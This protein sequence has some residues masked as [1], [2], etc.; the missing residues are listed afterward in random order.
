MAD[1]ADGLKPANE[2]PWYVLM[3]LYGEQ[4]G[5]EIDWDLHEKNKRAWNAWTFKRT[6]SATTDQL[7]ETKLNFLRD[8][9]IDRDS[10]RVSLLFRNRWNIKNKKTEPSV[11]VFSDQLDLSGTEFLNPLILDGFAFGNL[12]DLSGSKF[13]KGLSAQAAGFPKV[14]ELEEARSYKNINLVGSVFLSNLNAT[15]LQIDGIFDLSLAKVF[16]DFLFSDEYVS[17]QFRGKG[18][19]VE[20]KFDAFNREFKDDLIMRG[21]AIKGDVDFS[22]AEFHK[23]AHFIKATF[24][25]NIN[26]VWTTFVDE[27]N[28][29]GSTFKKRAIFRK[30]I[31]KGTVGF[32][33]SDFQGN[34]DFAE[35]VFAATGDNHMAAIRFTD[36]QFAKPTSFRNAR[37]LKSY[38]EFTNTDLHPVTDFSADTKTEKFWPKGVTEP[39]KEARETC[40]IIRNLLAKKGLHEDQHFFFRKE[41]QFAKASV[42]KREAFTYWVYGALS[43]FGDSIQRPVVCLCVVWI[44][45]LLIFGGFFLQT[46]LFIEACFEGQNRWPN[47][48]LRPYGTGAALSLSNLFPPFG[49]NRTFFG[50]KFM[51]CLPIPLKFFS[52]LQTIVSLPFLFFLGLG[53][54]QRFRLR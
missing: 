20:G 4:E 21:V 14:L 17:A 50:N 48:A 2:N 3:T 46:P 5:D 25:A 41:M 38:P 33:S 35:S 30:A 15:K 10:E 24:S 36:C 28:F 37:F 18:L 45:G 9:E 11:P 32:T 16:G 49:F 43:D 40:G 12:L 54:R 19:F 52:G 27:A 23:C 31:F 39:R 22:N 13:T 42:N 44:L 29:A 34:T 26:F 51:G 1:V 53:L 6:D 47:E 8:R 7:R